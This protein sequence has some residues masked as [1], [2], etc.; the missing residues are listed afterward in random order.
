MLLDEVL[1]LFEVLPVV[2][3]ALVDLLVVVRVGVDADGVAGSRLPLEAVKIA[4]EEPGDEEGGLDLVVVEDAEQLTGVLTGAVVEGQVDGFAVADDTVFDF[5]GPAEVRDLAGVVEIDLSVLNE[6]DTLFVRGD[7]FVLLVLSSLGEVVPGVVHQLDAAV[8][9]VEFAVFEVADAGLRFG[10]A[11]EVERGL[12]VFDIPPG[13]LPFDGAGLRAGH[14]PVDDAVLDPVPVVA[15]PGKAGE[16]VVE[17]T[18]VEVDPARFAGA[19]AGIGEVHL[20]VVDVV[21]PLPFIDRPFGGAGV[22]VL[23]LTLLVVDPV[24]VVGLPDAGVVRR[25]FAAAE[26]EEP[27]AEEQHQKDGSDADRVLAAGRQFIVLF[28]HNTLFF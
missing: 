19:E 7:A 10:G 22:V 27:E 18:F 24:F 4:L 5:V 2:F 20:A 16:G 26:G 11:V 28:F 14:G 9:L 17:D 13:R 3:G 1:H 6:P 21:G 12:A 25:R 23:D 15:G 8:V